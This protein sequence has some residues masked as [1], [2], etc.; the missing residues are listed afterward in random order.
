[1]SSCLWFSQRLCPSQLPSHPSCLPVSSSLHSQTLWGQH[2]DGSKCLSPV[3]AACAGRQCCTVTQRSPRSES[4]CGPA[5]R[6][7]WHVKLASTGGAWPQGGWLMQTPTERILYGCDGA[8]T[9]AAA[10]PARTKK[11]WSRWLRPDLW[12]RRRRKDEEVSVKEAKGVDGWRN[13]CEKVLTEW[14][15]GRKS[16][17]KTRRRKEKAVEI[18]RDIE[19]RMLIK[20][21]VWERRLG[22]KLE[23]E[24][25]CIGQ[26]GELSTPHLERQRRGKSGAF[27]TWWK[28]WIAAGACAMGWRGNFC[29]SK[30]ERDSSMSSP[31]PWELQV[32]SRL[33]ALADSFTLKAARLSARRLEGVQKKRRDLDLSL[34]CFIRDLE[35]WVMR[36]MP[37]EGCNCQTAVKGSF[38][39]T[40]RVS[41]GR[42]EGFFIASLNFVPCASAA[43]R[44]FT[45][46]TSKWVRQEWEWMRWSWT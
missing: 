39:L 7:S 22:R 18:E 33:S 30:G 37:W 32:S 10:T 46:S 12:E 24:K 41:D 17:K 31:A 13:V 36:R 44:L 42:D 14:T 38:P 6:F 1:M 23:E 19:C 9:A 20:L 4:L 28:A 45:A 26:G 29:R 27:S 21:K 8:A 43:P 5:G 15:R 2:L 11:M 35:R 16:K 40:V 3:C 34:C 25:T